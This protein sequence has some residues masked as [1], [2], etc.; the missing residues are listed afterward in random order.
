M[1]NKSPLNWAITGKV[2]T[3]VKYRGKNKKAKEEQA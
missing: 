3:V 1:F 2:Y